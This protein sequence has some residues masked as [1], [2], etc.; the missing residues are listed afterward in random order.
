MYNFGI[1]VISRFTMQSSYP[2]SLLSRLHV[3]DLPS[4]KFEPF[5][6]ISL[7]LIFDVWVST[8]FTVLDNS[9]SFDHYFVIEKQNE[10]PI[11]K[12]FKSAYPRNRRLDMFT[13]IP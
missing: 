5:N 13:T 7:L 4:G 8:C 11:I 6:K 10:A 9:S 3:Y 1:N 12:Q 2:I